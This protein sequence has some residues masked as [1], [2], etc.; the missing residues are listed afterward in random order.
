MDQATKGSVDLPAVDVAVIGAGIAGL[1]TA[2]YA[3][4]SDLSV[5]DFEQHTIPGGLCTSWKRKGYVFD[6]CIDYFMGSGPGV[7]FYDIWKELGVIGGREFRHMDVFGRY[8]GSNGQVFD[9]YIDHRGLK[10]HMLTIAPED[11]DRI[12]A[13][14][15]AIRQAR[16]MQMTELSFS[17]AGL[18]RLMRSLPALPVTA[19]WTRISVQEWCARLQNP[20]LR[21]AIPPVIGMVDFPM[22]GPIMVF[23]MMDCDKV[24]YPLG[25]SLPLALA[26]EKRASSIGAD[27]HYRQ[28]VRRVVVEDDRA[29]GI[30]LEDGR[31]Q[32]ARYVVAACD[33]RTVFDDLL[34]GRVRDSAYEAMFQKGEIHPSILQVSLGVRL[35]PAWHL[36]DMPRKTHFE[37][38]RPIIVDGRHQTRIGIHHYAHDP[39][40]APEGGTVILVR[41]ASNY[42]RWEALRADR[43]AYRA[44][45]RRLLDDTIRALEEP[46]PGLRARVEASDVATPTTF[47]RYTGNWRGSI[48]AWIL[49]QELAGALMS[50]PHLPKTFDD[51]DGFHLIGQWTGPPSGLPPAARNGRDVIRAIMRTEGTQAA[52]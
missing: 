30:E 15:T 31:V 6:Y 50:G 1:S 29:V 18:Y 25:G 36:R 11:A 33:A 47:V 32:S 48:Q 39:S 28:R 45:K 41:Y 22:A 44:E 35:D 51:V 49:T 46:F 19:N 43:S 37:L 9:L 26:V 2:V 10:E 52:R 42:D 17:L 38:E 24:G 3:R 8:V 16:S 4:L 5:R 34:E 23:A 40:M 20:F 7:D 14:C 12:R 13:F 21:R 27:F